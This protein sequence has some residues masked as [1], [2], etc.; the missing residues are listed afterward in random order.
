MIKILIMKIEINKKASLL[1]MLLIA[2]LGL[3]AQILRLPLSLL[4]AAV[5]SA[6]VTFANAPEISVPIYEQMGI[7]STMLFIIM[8]VSHLFCWQ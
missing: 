6:P 2:N 5:T 8:N 3:M 7:S 4:S 1:M